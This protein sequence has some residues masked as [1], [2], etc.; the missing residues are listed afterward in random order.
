M[1]I[2]DGLCDLC[3]EHLGEK[4]MVYGNYSRTTG[5][6]WCGNC[7]TDGRSE[8]YR[9]IYDKRVEITVKGKVTQEKKNSPIFRP[10]WDSYYLGIA[11]AVSAR[12]DCVRAQHGAVIVKNHK[13]I[14]TGYNGSPPK[15]PNSCG[16]TGNCPRNNDPNAKHSEGDYDSCWATHAEANALMRA[17]WEEMQGAVIY[18]TGRPCPGCSKLIASSGIIKIVTA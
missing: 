4:G 10:D 12:G 9:W 5:R 11:K 2:Q 8:I 3:Q 17:S 16:Q 6:L 1:S 15:S 7:H 14:S 13:I 18:I